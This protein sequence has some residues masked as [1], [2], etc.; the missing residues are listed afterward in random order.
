MIV[1]LGGYPRGYIAEPQQSSFRPSA[2]PR[3]Y[4]WIY[5]RVYPRARCN[6]SCFRCGPGKATGLNAGDLRPRKPQSLHASTIL[7]LRY[8]IPVFFQQVLAE[9]P[10]PCGQLLDINTPLC[11]NISQRY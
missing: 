4:P 9:G 8:S 2:R 5:P 7:T 1:S 10:T 11:P 6:S 3:I